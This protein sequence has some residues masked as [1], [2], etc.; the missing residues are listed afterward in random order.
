MDESESQKVE[1]VANFGSLY[2]AFK[3]QWSVAYHLDFVI[4]YESTEGK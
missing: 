2:K 1:L 4:L 3:Q